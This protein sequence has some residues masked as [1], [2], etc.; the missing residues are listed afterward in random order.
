MWRNHI[1]LVLFCKTGHGKRPIC[2]PYCVPWPSS[3]AE[4]ALAAELPISLTQY[5]LSCLIHLLLSVIL[6]SVDVLSPTNV[7]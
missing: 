1:S 3:T 6:D 4:I 2:G 7:T 5:K